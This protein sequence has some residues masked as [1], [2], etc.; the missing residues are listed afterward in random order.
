MV[1]QSTAG[2][3]D[4]PNRFSE[5]LRRRIH[6]CFA[7]LPAD[8]PEARE[9][10]KEAEGHVDNRDLQRV[11]LS[12]AGT[13]L[14]DAL[15]TALLPKRPDKRDAQIPSPRPTAKELEYDRAIQIQLSNEISTL[16][17][18]PSMKG[19]SKELSGNHDVEHR[20]SRRP[21]DL[22][23]A[24]SKS[25]LAPPSISNSAPSPQG[26][27][28]TPPT[29]V[30]AKVS[31]DTYFQIPKF[32]ER[33][34]AQRTSSPPAPSDPPLSSIRSKSTGT[35]YIMD[36]SHESFEKA[37]IRNL[38]AFICGLP[39]RYPH[40]SVFY[41]LPDD[42]GHTREIHA[43]TLTRA[44]AVS[45]SIKEEVQ[46]APAG[47]KSR[48]LFRLRKKS[49]KSETFNT[50]S[51]RLEASQCN[52][53]L[54][55]NNEE[56]ISNLQTWGRKSS[57]ETLRWLV[58]KLNSPKQVYLIMGYLTYMDPKVSKENDSQTGSHN[59]SY[60]TLS[61]PTLEAAIA[62]SSGR[63]LS[64]GLFYLS[65]VDLMQLTIAGQNL[66]ELDGERVQAGFFREV[67]LG[68]SL[69]KVTVYNVHR[70]IMLG[71]PI[72]VYFWG[73]RKRPL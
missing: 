9:V 49:E 61:V 23:V 12:P 5:N 71:D 17:V 11:T 43:E 63:G 31:A 52:E 8:R 13:I 68:C 29:A 32:E 16:N 62:G 59:S 57:S 54:L 20:S 15:P 3:L 34:S 47:T 56:W 4:F 64:S 22:P 73:P 26:D 46:D 44:V 28:S 19:K 10:F 35:S 53:Y 66:L 45:D 41:D 40:F 67:T 24:A 55:L 2:H 1:A 38:G 69:D 70:N 50:T 37:L 30:P 65:V 7:Y 14:G 27:S 21:S 72:S 39:D 51:I 58:S 48:S 36:F 33:N 18:D 6:S 42:S 25:E 60:G